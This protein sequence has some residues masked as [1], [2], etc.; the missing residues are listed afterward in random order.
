MASTPNAGRSSMRK[1][2]LRTASGLL[3]LATIA[4]TAAWAGNFTVSAPVQVS[5]ADPFAGCTADNAATQV[6]RLFPDSTV[7]PWVEVNPAKAS[8][9]VATW[10]QDR[11]SNGGARGLVA[12][13]SIDGG[14][15]WS[16]VV[17]PNITSCSAVSPTVVEFQRAS[18]P[19][20]TFA[21]NGDLYHVSLSIAI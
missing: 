8:N 11:W 5:G 17:I 7:E 4:L 20:L 1:R 16:Q 9:I 15:S 10:Q 21:P 14:A 2:P 12:G 3:V 19:W 6:G 18:D 13:V